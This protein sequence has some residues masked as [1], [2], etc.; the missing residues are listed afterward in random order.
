VSPHSSSTAFLLEIRDKTET[1]FRGRK[2]YPCPVAI[3]NS[4]ISVRLITQSA[5]FVKFDKIR[6]FL[7]FWDIGSE[8]VGLRVL[9]EVQRRRA[10]GFLLIAKGTLVSGA[11][12][13]AGA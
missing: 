2:A 6:S 5:I 13:K 7:F 11:E 10:K 12:A 1:T 9:L 3:L 8:C 4:K